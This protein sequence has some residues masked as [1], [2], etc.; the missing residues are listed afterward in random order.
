MDPYSLAVYIIG[1]GLGGI[2]ANR[3]DG[4]YCQ[5]L[6]AVVNHMQSG[7]K[8][9]NH[10]LQRGVRK[11]YLQ[12]TQVVCEAR[13]IE[14]GI[15]PN[16][17][18]RDIGRIIGLGK[19]NEEIFWLDKAHKSMSIELGNLSHNEYVPPSIESLKRIELLLLPK[20]STAGDRVAELRI[21]LSKDLLDELQELHGLPPRR[22][23]EMINKGWHDTAPDGSD[24]RL[25][26][27]DLLSAFFAH[28]LKT[29]EKLRSIFEGQLLAQ[30]SIG[31]IPITLKALEGQFKEFGKTTIA[32]LDRLDEKIA[33]MRVEQKEDF[34]A[35]QS[36]IDE[37]LPTLAMISNI[38]AQQQTMNALINMILRELRHR[39]LY[40]HYTSGE[41][42]AKVEEYLKSY[43][44]L[45]VGREEAQSQLEAFLVNK[46]SG[47]LVVSAPAGFGKTAILANLVKELHGNGYYVAHHFFT[48]RFDVTRPLINAFRNLLKQIYFYFD[49]PEESLPEDEM[50]LRDTLYG[51]FQDHTI[52][53]EEPLIILLDG[54]DEAERPF[55]PPFPSPLPE[56]LYIIVSGRC[57]EGEEPEYL[58][59]WIEGSE[60]LSLAHLSSA[61]VKE[62]L[63]RIGEGKLTK[64]AS[65][66]KFVEMVVKKT[67]GVPLYLQFLSD[68]LLQAAC[69]DGK[70]QN[71]KSVL[72]RSPKGFDK[73][74][75]EQF[76][77][78]T[79]IDDVKNQPKIRDLFALLS[80]ALGPL[81]D[82]DV[83]AITKLDEFDLQALPWQVTRWFSIHSEPV[84][85]DNSQ[86]TTYSFTYSLL[87]EKFRGVIKEKVEMV[88]ENLLEYCSQWR[89]H[90]SL[91]TLQHY[92]EHLEKSNKWK[93]LFDLASDR[94]F[95]YLQKR[96]FPNSP[97]LALFTLQ[98]ALRGAIK[99][100]NAATMTE[101]VLRHAREIIRITT[102][103]NPLD[104]LRAGYL[105]RA[106]KLSDLFEFERNVLWHLLIAW[107]L[108]DKKKMDEA[109]ATLLRLAQKKL[110]RLPIQ[111]LWKV[112]YI[113][114]NIFE[115]N[116]STID[117]LYQQLIGD[118][119]FNEL[120]KVHSNNEKI[121]NTL[122]IAISQVHAGKFSDAIRTIK[123]IKSYDG[124]ST[125]LII[126]AE[127]L[128]QIGE[129]ENARSTI[130]LT[131][132]PPDEIDE[133]L[134]HV[135][136]LGV[137]SKSLAEHGEFSTALKIVNGIR[138]T[139]IQSITLGYISG[140]QAK[141]GQIETAQSTFSKAI[142]NSQ[143]IMDSTQKALAL[144]E[145]MIR[146]LKARQSDNAKQ[147]LK[148]AIEATNE[149][150]NENRR[151]A[152]LYSM[153]VNQSKENLYSAILETASHI[154]INPPKS[155]ALSI[156]AIAH[157]KA[158]YHELAV[159]TAESIDSEKDRQ[160]ALLAIIKYFA[161]INELELAN[162][163]VI[164][165]EELTIRAQAQ[166][167]IALK[168]YTT[169]KSNKAQV[170]FNKVTEFLTMSV[171]RSIQD[172]L[173]LAIVEYLATIGEYSKANEYIEQMKYS[174]TTFKAQS[175][176]NLIKGC[177]EGGEDARNSFK[178]ALENA[179][180]TDSF[181]GTSDV[182][183]N[184]INTMINNGLNS[185]VVKLADETINYRNVLLSTLAS[186]LAKDYDL[187]N[188]EKIII[189]SAYYLDTSYKLFELLLILYPVLEIKDI[190]TIMAAVKEYISELENH[191][192]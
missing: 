91:Y 33:K 106:W 73:Y 60:R 159:Q 51:I 137:L 1:T 172:E 129:L 178:I 124:Y 113:F 42:A 27:F 187:T 20:D 99:S 58:Q 57:N 7:G 9:V 148:L 30:I 101:F 83:R 175:I 128:V 166:V 109:Q 13:M 181:W 139:E 165:I 16:T 155:W 8:P 78:L 74:V 38:D 17:L 107:E 145:I 149:H 169:G 123:S 68:D 157:A 61:E 97:E 86:I 138:D 89:E 50:G 2:V 153:V 143:L 81:S 75:R 133:E 59:G 85:Q 47:K 146:Q 185:L 12:A 160:T 49:L 135:T 21:T 170:L 105:E 14:L 192:R 182:L 162:A 39:E 127:R 171:D 84:K 29:N 65:D 115:L 167:S 63:Q 118:I 117:S 5:S 108:K 93:E 72:E 46:P 31:D 43:S 163:T 125:E 19:S 177:S 126:F 179:I 11:A 6:G 79:C 121:E 45:F 56:G 103:E 34:S 189:P 15:S 92:A 55:S 36:H 67:E 87:A 100:G 90:Y 32:Q 102:R 141:A 151:D 154:E 156:V 183:E 174:D 191:I 152:A 28:E 130:A 142:E 76:H 70:E 120:E 95:R 4:L 44:L 52:F 48:N 25:D 18:K 136:A 173:L 54:L 134:I 77:Q 37:I 150:S 80:I 53:K 22:F 66:D 98:I 62:Y 144:N 24:R 188:F 23:K 26:W 64:Y 104:T 132:A 94:E 116:K 186:I 114:K 180:R 119:P 40:K 10:D 110:T 82:A 164:K 168:L 190:Y 147:A 111:Y 122:E 96:K 3:I 131:L 41:V 71:V 69:S 88:H 176:I 112:S 184:V 140:M 35:L 161:E 158:G